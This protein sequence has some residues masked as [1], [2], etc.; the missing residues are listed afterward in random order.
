MR[1]FCFACQRADPV[2][3][4]SSLVDLKI[5]TTVIAP[6]ILGP[7]LSELPNLR[8]LHTLDVAIVRDWDSILVL[9]DEIES[10]EDAN[11]IQSSDPRFL[12]ER[13]SVE[14]IFAWAS[15]IGLFSSLAIG[16]SSLERDVDLANQWINSSC[17]TLK[18]LFIYWDRVLDDPGACL[19]ISHWR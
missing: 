8:R 18:C 16:V 10:S 6:D 15:Q 9:P 5:D 11:D 7:F 14:G 17:E 13:Y 12:P 2:P 4:A 19:D 1:H 3:L